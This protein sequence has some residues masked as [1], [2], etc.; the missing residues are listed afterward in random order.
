[1]SFQ[2]KSNLAVLVTFLLTYGWYFFSMFGQVQAAG[3][4]VDGYQAQML[5]M[6][7]VFVLLVI[8]AHIGIAV[9]DPE[10]TDAS[11][12]RDRDINRWG[13]YVGGFVLGT[14]ALVALALAMLEV[15]HFYIAHAILA[16]LVL[17]EI[18]G[19]VTKIV[20]YRRGY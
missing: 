13:E 2:E 18:V 17:S 19:D 6:I 9:L 1:M 10:S 11:D 12:E 16:F 20:L 4:P 5:V 3:G 15:A 8:V 14:G 7:V